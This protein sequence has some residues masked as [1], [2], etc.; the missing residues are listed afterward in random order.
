VLTLDS[1]STARIWSERVTVT[2]ADVLDTFADGPAAGGAA[3]TRH[4][5]GDGTAWY[6]ATAPEEHAYAEL[7]AS[8]VAQ[9]GIRAIPEAGTDVE[10]L[11]RQGG[12][13]SFLF[14]IN[15]ANTD[16][17]VRASGDDLITG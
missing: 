7:M 2:G 17:V 3:L 13:R 10:I 6:L 9:A 5:H 1:G 12:G 4:T 8:V 11:R 15:H 16:V 14:I